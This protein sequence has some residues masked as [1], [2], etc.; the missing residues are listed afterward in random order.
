MVWYILQVPAMVL[1]VKGQDGHIASGMTEWKM[2]PVS[3]GISIFIIS[4][5]RLP[6]RIVYLSRQMAVIKVLLMEII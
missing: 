4:P 1:P 6:S 3:K 2:Y 5:L